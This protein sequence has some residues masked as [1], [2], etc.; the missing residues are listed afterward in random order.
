MVLVACSS[1]I[2]QGEQQSAL[3]FVLPT[4]T[5]LKKQLNALQ[6]TSVEPLPSAYRLLV[7]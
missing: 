6:V 4:L 3:A 2:L 7:F 5:V 1:D